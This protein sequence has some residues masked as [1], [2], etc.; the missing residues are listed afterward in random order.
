MPMLDIT[1]ERHRKVRDK[2]IKIILRLGLGVAC[3]GAFW[4]AQAESIPA[5]SARWQ[6]EGKAKATEHLG[7]RCLW[8]QD[9]AASLKDFEM[10]DGVIDVDMA[11]SGAPGVYNIHFRTQGDGNGEE[12]YLRPH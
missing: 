4:A 6:L 9:G 2:S 11:G 5:D 7:R 1:N 3:L 10:T 8:L 12:V